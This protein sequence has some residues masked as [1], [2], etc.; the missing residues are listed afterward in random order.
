MRVKLSVHRNRLPP[1]A[2]LWSIPEDQINPGTTVSKL[3][4]QIDEIIPLE[5]DEWGFE[6]YIVEVDGFE[7]MHFQPVGDVIKEGDVIT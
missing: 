2:V 6:D 3:L 7:C 5:A 4:Q 1:A